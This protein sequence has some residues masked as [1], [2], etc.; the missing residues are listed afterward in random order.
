MIKNYLGDYDIDAAEPPVGWVL[1]YIQEHW[2]NND[3][4]YLLV[5]RMSSRFDDY[6]ELIEDFGRFLGNTERRH[7][8]RSSD[9]MNDAGM[10]DSVEIVDFRPKVRKPPRIPDNVST[11]ESFCPPISKISKIRK[12]K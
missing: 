6:A 4:G 2:E 7:W 3:Q 11:A 9:W 1:D 10:H 12:R 8:N 5:K